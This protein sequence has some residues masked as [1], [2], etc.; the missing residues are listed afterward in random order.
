MA[1]GRSMAEMI[2]QRNTLGSGRETLSPAVRPPRSQPAGR[3]P[4]EP[5][6]DQTSVW[7]PAHLGLNDGQASSLAAE[8]VD[9]CA[10]SRTEVRRR[11]LHVLPGVLPL[12]LWPFPHKDPLAPFLGTI[13]YSLGV[14]VTVGVYLAERFVHRDE[15]RSWTQAVLGYSLAV[16]GTIFLFP[17]HLEISFAVLAILAFGDGTATLG[18][19]LVG[20]PTIPW[21][22]NKTY[23][24]MA[25][26][27]VCA[28]VMST[29]VYWGEAQPRVSWF[30]AA[31]CGVVPTVFAAL[32]ESLPMRLNDNIRVGAV[33]AVT[34][35][36]TH[37]V[38]VGL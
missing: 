3:L 28:G 17:A 22:R 36:G 34:A 20:G 32:A 25:S 33:A 16:M 14:A 23:A 31:I 2:G 27:V 7:H 37:A 35:V 12:L 19:K 38:V 8:R 24:G 30:T 4:R 21:N 10:L 26:F 11:L 13:I 18:G 1:K 15:E 5:S 29:V 9:G 6:A